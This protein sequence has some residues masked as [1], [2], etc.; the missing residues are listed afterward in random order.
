MS[1]QKKRIIKRYGNRKLYDTEMSSYITL[2]KLFTEIRNGLNILVVDNKTRED[3]TYKTLVQILAEMERETVQN[4]NDDLLVRVIRSSKE[5][6]FS[7][8][9]G[10]L[11]NQVAMLK[12]KASDKTLKDLPSGASK[13]KG[14]GRQLSQ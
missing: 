14:E 4:K 13:E 10:M 9:I 8:Y 12:G 5:G 3:I 7:S 6:T 11:E 1:E 2:E